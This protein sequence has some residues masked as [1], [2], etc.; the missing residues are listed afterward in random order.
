[1]K[2][3]IWV[4]TSLQPGEG[5][6]DDVISQT[7]EIWFFHLPLLG[8]GRL[9]NLILPTL[10]SSSD[11]DRN[12]YL[13]IESISTEII[14]HKK[15]YRFFKCAGVLWV[16]AKFWLGH[17]RQDIATGWLHFRQ[18]RWCSCL[19]KMCCVDQNE[20]WSSRL[21]Q[22]IFWSVMLL[23]RFSCKMQSKA[24]VVQI[25]LWNVN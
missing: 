4:L 14:I 9:W 10:E 17:S 11:S 13:S 5:R 7:S 18:L 23:R 2:T 15:K 19:L 8:V 21:F 25:L 6:K 22:L 24:E 12:F 16:Y 1:M 3:K 20:W